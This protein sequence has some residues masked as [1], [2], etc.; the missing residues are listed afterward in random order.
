M[1]WNILGVGSPLVDLLIN[2]DDAF[3]KKHVSGA[4]GGMEMV[5]PE[6]ITALTAAYGSSP[7]MAP[8]GSAGNTIFALAKMGISCSMLGKLGDDSFG[9]FY[10][11]EFRK[12]GGSDNC[13][14]AATEAPT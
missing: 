12:N 1:A 14:I 6:V 4:K 9:S 8:G 5:E 2:V 3:L 11:G 13:F 7:C 10:R